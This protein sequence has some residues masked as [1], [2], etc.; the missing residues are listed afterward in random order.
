MKN[1]LDSISLLYEKRE[2]SRTQAFTI[3]R[4]MLKNSKKIISRAHY[5]DQLKARELREENFRHLSDLKKIVG[6][7]RKLKHD[8]FVRE[9]VEEF[10]EADLYL[11]YVTAGELR[12]DGRILRFAD[13]DPDIVIAGL[14]DFTGE[15]TR[16]AIRISSQERSAEVQKISELVNKIIDKLLEIDLAGYSRTKFDQAKR[17]AQRLEMMLY[18]LRIRS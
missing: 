9:G 6:K 15:L 4:A 14:C 1:V 8:G 10:A 2:S 18:E 3:A 16:R 12:L 13:D 7:N 11:N 17:N 5:D